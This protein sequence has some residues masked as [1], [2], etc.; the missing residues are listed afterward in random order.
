MWLP[1]TLQWSYLI[2]PAAVSLCLGIVMIILVCYSKRNN[3]LGTDSGSSAILF[4]WRFT[5]TLVAVLYV[6]MT[7]IL[8][9]DLKRTEP[10]YRL[11]G[12]PPG[13]ASAYGTVLQSPRAWWSIFAD[14]C[15][16]RKRTGKTSLGLIC[17]AIINVV[18]L[19]AISPLSSAL[20]T[21]EEISITRP[22]QF[23]RLVPKSNALISAIAT[24]ETYFRTLSALT[25]NVST[26]AWVTDSSLTFP[27]WPAS[28]VAQLGPDLVSPFSAWS[29]PSTT[30]H[31]EY[32]CQ[33]MDLVSAEMSQK[34]YS[35][36]YSVQQYG[37]YNGTQPMVTF[38]LESGDGCRYELSIHPSADIAS[39]GG[40]TW[41]NSSTFFP[42]SAQTLAVGGLVIPANVTSTHIFARLNVSEE[43]NGRDVILMSTAWAIALN[44]TKTGPFIPKN[45]TYERSPKF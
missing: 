38:V 10:F 19:L 41:S 24:R 5:P 12:A 21:S 6:Q 28:E 3:G 26:S 37:P 32:E 18:A 43:C 13:G 33:E 7:V 1:F 9:E 34:H 15:L 42:T 8:F 14:V 29:V 36:V 20:P 23:T 44:G 17:A 39:S 25:R 35:Q 40:V 27:F 4:G 31:S 45:Q 11:A 22:I 2:L 30:V 16:R